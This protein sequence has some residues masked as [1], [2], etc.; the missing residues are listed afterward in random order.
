MEL[1][2]TVV[3]QTSFSSFFFCRK[4]FNLLFIVNMLVRYLATLRVSL[5]RKNCAAERDWMEMN[6]DKNA[7]W[8]WLLGCLLILD[9]SVLNTDKAKVW[10]SK[11]IG[12]TRKS[13]IMQ[14]F[15]L[16]L[17]KVNKWIPVLGAK[18]QNDNSLFVSCNWISSNSKKLISSD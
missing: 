3:S 5:M 6:L 16:R 14:G 1:W 15:N 17:C 2:K 10:V 9:R 4:C 8:H 7:F 12:R 11:H 13:Y 18:S